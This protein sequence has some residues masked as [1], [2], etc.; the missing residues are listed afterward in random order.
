MHASFSELKDFITYVRPRRIVPC[1]IPFGD[2]SLSDVCARYMVMY[3]ALGYTLNIG[4]LGNVKS[5]LYSELVWGRVKLLSFIERYPCSGWGVLVGCFVCD[6]CYWMNPGSRDFYLR[7]K[8]AVVV[9]LSRKRNS[10]R[11]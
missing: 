4:H 5:I 1:V 8:L 3:A 11:D 10:E 9:S 6:N 7:L 2:A